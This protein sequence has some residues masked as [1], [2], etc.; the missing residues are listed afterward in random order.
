MIHLVNAEL[1]AGIHNL[2][3]PFCTNDWDVLI[4]RTQIL[5]KC[6]QAFST[7][8]IDN[9]AIRIQLA[10][11]LWFL[12]AMEMTRDANSNGRLSS[13]CAEE[14]D[15][16]IVVCGRAKAGLQKFFGKDYLPVLM[17]RSRVAYLVMLWAHKQNHDARDITMSI[18]CSKAWIVN[19]KRLA[20]TITDKCVRCR[21][22][23]KLKVQQQQ[24]APLP[25]FVQTTCS[26]FTN[27]GVDLC[28][29]LVVRSMTNKRATMT[30]WNVIFVCLNTKVVTM[31][32]APGY[33]TDDFMLAYSSHISDHGLPTNVHSDK[34]SQLQ[35]AG[36]EVA[37]FE[38]D[39]IAQTASI[40]GTTWEFA[41]TGAQWR[42]G[43]VEIFVKKFKKSF[44]ILYGQTRLNFAELACAVKRVSNVLNDRPLSVQKSSS[45]YPDQDRNSTRAPIDRDINLCLLYTSPSPRDS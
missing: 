38:W 3:D 4:H 34:G 36:R 8:N 25:S 9:E 17:G 11:K 19:A 29:P 35:A 23:H 14:R 26:P 30:V 21:Y 43:A 1:V 15:G 10:E 28:G 20:T 40:Q 16:L 5:I 45:E 37:N 33:A 12:D 22:L 31:Y 32:L 13:L 7:L 6:A 27:V 18:A 24:M 42:N 41:P 39:V 2:I 44:E